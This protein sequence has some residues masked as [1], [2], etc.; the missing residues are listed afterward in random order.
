MAKSGQEQ[1]VLPP[2]EVNRAVADLRRGDIV[3]LSD[4]TDAALIQAAE[5]I[6]DE[7]LARAHAF[8]RARPVLAT[9]LRRAIAL[10]LAPEE[11]AVG[12]AVELLPPA[13]ASAAF[14]R[15]LA[16]PTV[17]REVSAAPIGISRVGSKSLANAAIELAKL[18]RLLPAIACFPIGPREG[19]LIARREGIIEVGL[20]QVFAHRTVLARTLRQVAEANVP[21]VDAEHTRIIAFRPDD[22]GTDHLAILIGE[23]KGPAPVLARIH[24]ECFTGDLLGSLRCDCG[25]QLRG[26]IKAIS[27]AGS[28]IVIYLAQEGRGI[29][30]VNKLRAYTLQDAGFDTVDANLQLGFDADERVYQPAAEILRQLGFDKVRLMTNNPEKV[31]ALA[32]HDIEI[33]ERVPSV[34]ASNDHNRN[35]L[36]T[37]AKRSGHLF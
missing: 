10:E 5:A 18:A 28:G 12:V 9:T 25:D 29:G 33:V 22:G 21:L 15:E 19:A 2:H 17:V 20:D 34:F 31:A 6:D 36:A 26:A 32:Q 37:K 16:D 11:D 23:P 8:T 4:G 27:E 1:R 3:L 14:L 7:G 24:S 13:D 35:Y 30:L